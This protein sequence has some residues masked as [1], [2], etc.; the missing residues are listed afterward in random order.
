MYERI[1][2]KRASWK[3]WKRTVCKPHSRTASTAGLR[4][5]KKRRPIS[6]RSFANPKLTGTAGYTSRWIRCATSWASRWP[7]CGRSQI[8]RRSRTSGVSWVI[9]RSLLEPRFLWINL[10]LFELVF[11]GGYTQVPTCLCSQRF[12]GSTVEFEGTLLKNQLV[13]LC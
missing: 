10:N 13:K 7:N 3:R 8:G 12:F 1:I 5:R 2:S 4:W 11:S 6:T 9:L